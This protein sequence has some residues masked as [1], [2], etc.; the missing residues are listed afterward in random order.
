MSGSKIQSLRDACVSF[1]QSCNF[2]DTALALEP[3]S[4]RECEAQRVPLSCFEPFLTTTV[5]MLTSHGSTPMAEAMDFVL[6]TYSLTRAVLVS[7]GQPDSEESVYEV[8]SRYREASLPCDCVHIGDS[9]DGEACLRKVAEMTGGQYI[10]FTDITSFSRSFKYLT[11]AFY[12]QLTSGGV[13]A[14]QLGAKEIK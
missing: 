14:A 8:A 13:T 5:Q 4:T 9:T 12:G 6:Q 11:P 10:K 1:I 2:S 3:F 7:D